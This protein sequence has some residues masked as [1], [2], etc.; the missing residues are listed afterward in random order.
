MAG[1]FAVGIVEGDIATDLD[2]AKLGGR[3]AQIALLNTNNGFGGECH[4]TLPWSTVPWPVW[5]CPRWTW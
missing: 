1:E 4:L 5:I 2:A 3:G